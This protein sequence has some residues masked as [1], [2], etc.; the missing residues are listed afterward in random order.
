MKLLRDT[1]EK[2]LEFIADA[3]ERFNKSLDVNLHNADKAFSSAVTTLNTVVSEMNE[4]NG[5]LGK[6]VDGLK[7]SA[8]VFSAESK[9]TKEAAEALSASLERWRTSAKERSDALGGSVTALQ[10]SMSNLQ[11]AMEAQNAAKAQNVS[12]MR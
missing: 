6:I 1:H 4:G 11:K 12:E 7:T 2:G 8:D 3:F 9:S 5:K 10:S